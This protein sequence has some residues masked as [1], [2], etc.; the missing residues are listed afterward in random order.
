MVVSDF[1]SESY[2]GWLLLEV[3]VPRTP[4]P[5]APTPRPRA[6]AHGLAVETKPEDGGAEGTLQVVHAGP[7]GM[8]VDE[9][10]QAGQTVA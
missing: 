6:P 10:R 2:G 7:R 4:P 1:Q 3:S 9:G 8:E 5:N